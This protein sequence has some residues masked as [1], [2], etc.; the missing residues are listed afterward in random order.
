ML[1]TLQTRVIAF[2]VAEL[3]QAGR[4]AAGEHC[5]SKRVKPAHQD[6]AH[7]KGIRFRR[8]PCIATESEQTGTRET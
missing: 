1:R 7:A 4:H 2:P 3:P 6:T 5:G 8:I